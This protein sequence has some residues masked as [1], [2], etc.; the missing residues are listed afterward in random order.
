M[1]DK[2]QI[3][4]M[5]NILLN[6]KAVTLEPNVQKLYSQH[7][8]DE[9]YVSNNDGHLTIDYGKFATALYNKNYRKVPKGSIVV[10]KEYLKT[11]LQGLEFQACMEMA[12]KCR[13]FVHQ[14]TGDDDGLLF[15]LED[16]IDEQLGVKIKWRYNDDDQ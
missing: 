6:L 15:D 3:E 10:D 16:F 1:T 5:K 13:D 12:K 14:W 11:E 8:S 2:Q 7:H 9:F 4:E